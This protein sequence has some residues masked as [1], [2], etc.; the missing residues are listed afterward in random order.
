MGKNTG[1]LPKRKLGQRIKSVFKRRPKEPQL[2]SG[3]GMLALASVSHP[4]ASKSNVGELKIVS[5]GDKKDK[6]E[7]GHEGWIHFAVDLY[8][9]M[10]IKP[11]DAFISSRKKCC[12]CMLAEL[13]KNTIR[14]ARCGLIIMPGDGVALY[15]R[16]GNE[17]AYAMFAEDGQAI[18]CMRWKCCPSGGLMVGNWDGE[19]IAASFGGESMAA[20]CM[21]S[22][23]VLF[24]NEDGATP[25]D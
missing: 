4:S 19:K 21:S 22:G 24:Y 25:I 13:A 8:G 5:L 17:P 18:G 6:F 12:E 9:E 7:C 10:Q 23:N 15:K 16:T 20:A 11:H 1:K 2:V 3:S 14:C